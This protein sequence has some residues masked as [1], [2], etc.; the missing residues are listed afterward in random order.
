METSFHARLGFLI[1]D[2]TR[3]YRREFDR[4]SADLGLTRGQWRALRRLA[5]FEGMTQ[6]ELAADLELA[7][8][9]VGRVLDRLEKAGFVERRPDP[10]DR[11]CWRLY[12]T[13]GSA[14]V[15]AAVDGIAD[16]LIEEI[17]SDVA[18]RDLQATERV[19]LTIKQRLLAVAA[20]GVTDA[21]DD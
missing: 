9:A 1:G 8:I 3:L 6:V 4:R 17:F 7:P 12:L 16:G 15:M 10:K 2:V 13:P 20:P 11:R 19:L 21:T 18:M 5:R 14:A